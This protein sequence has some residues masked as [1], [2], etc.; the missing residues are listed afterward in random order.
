MLKLIAY[1]EGT[2]IHKIHGTG[3]HKKRKDS[4]DGV[5]FATELEFLKIVVPRLSQHTSNVNTECTTKSK[6]LY[7]ILSFTL[8][9]LIYLI[10]L[11]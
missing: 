9:A 7:S 11:F 6:Q 3:T 10:L 8:G 1:F 5:L 2:G 4:L